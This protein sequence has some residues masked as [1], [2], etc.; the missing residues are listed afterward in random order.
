MRAL[1]VSAAMSQLAS[2][3]W[4]VVEPSGGDEIVLEMA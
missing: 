1:D 4:Q 2:L 3:A